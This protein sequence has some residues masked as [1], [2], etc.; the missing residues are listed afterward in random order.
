MPSGRPW[1]AWKG[2]CLDCV[3]AEEMAAFYGRLLGWPVT[4]R[5]TPEDRRGGSGWVGMDDPGGG[6]GLSFQAEDWYQPPAWP[7]EAGHQAKMMHFEVFVDNLDAAVAEVI[8]AGGHQAPHQP[9]DR[10]RAQH[11]VMLDPAGHPFCLCT[12]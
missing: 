2:V 11:R 6:V 10:D 4:R 1:I 5:D 7:E 3:D 8:A 12:E 9:G